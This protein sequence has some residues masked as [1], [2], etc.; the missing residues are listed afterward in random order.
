MSADSTRTAVRD[1]SQA[2]TGWFDALEERWTDDGWD[3]LNAGTAEWQ[4]RRS[5]AAAQQAPRTGPL[6]TWASDI[7]GPL[8]VAGPGWAAPGTATVDTGSTE[9]PDLDEWN[10]LESRTGLTGSAA[11]RTAAPRS[12]S[13]PAGLDPQTYRERDL[14]DTG[15]YSLAVK[16]GVA[17]ALIA[18]AAGGSTAVA[19]DKEVTV[20]VDGVDQ[21]V[22]TFSG[23]VAGALSSGDIQVGPTDQMSPSPDA[24]IR[25]G[26]RLVVNHS[27]QVNLVVDGK[28]Q[29]IT[30]TATTVA[31]ALGQ[32]GMPTQALA[33][34]APLG[35]L[36]PSTGM[37]LAVALPKTITFV[38][39]GGAPQQLT[40][41]ATSLQDLLAQRG[42]QMGP[43]DAASQTSLVDG[44]AI[45]ITRNAVTQ[46][47]ETKPIAPPMQTVEDPTMNAG[48][49]KVDQPG[50]AGEQVQAFTVNTTNGKETA[51]TATGA[52]TVTKA[53][54]GGVIRKGTKKDAPAIGSTAKWDRMAKCEAGGDWSI[55][56]GNG[57][58]GGLQFDKQTWNAYG[59]GKYAAR[60]DLA[61]K[62][63]QIAV[64][65]KVR[66]ARGG[67]GAWPVCG[68]K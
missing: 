19:L 37:N 54:V 1:D 60:A 43:L 23:T 15:R 24:P 27:R 50:Q 28:P 12:V 5:D 3:G 57:Y 62:E 68:K 16:G 31:E 49:T 13:A 66:D 48:T 21:V 51:R 35:A 18:V 63:E 64:A 2:D 4:A 8:P 20:S 14:T 44:A 41:T 53:P 32:L 36:I 42:L 59:G 45:T 11:T 56:T 7:T 52:P 33:A 9:V 17:A 26:D 61:S 55:N 10:D 46:V 29:T 65:E 47:T 30:T 6:P 22:H 38:D 40:T 25:D 67:Y 58:Y 34:S 39:G